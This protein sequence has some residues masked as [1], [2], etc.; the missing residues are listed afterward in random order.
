MPALDIKNYSIANAR[1]NRYPF[2]ISI[3]GSGLGLLTFGINRLIIQ[4]ILNKCDVYKYIRYPNRKQPLVIPYPI[5]ED[6]KYIYSIPKRYINY[7]INKKLYINNKYGLADIRIIKLRNSN[8]LRVKK[9]I[10]IYSQLIHT[11]D[12]G[13]FL[14]FCMK[15]KKIE[16]SNISITE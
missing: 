7:E 16:Y 4:P 3:E 12:Y 14:K 5:V 13:S 9:N 2:T 11:S 10:K 6:E 1:D 15:L 8:T